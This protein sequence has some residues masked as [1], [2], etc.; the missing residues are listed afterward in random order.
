MWNLNSLGIL[1]L[2]QIFV[3][4]GGSNQKQMLFWCFIALTG[5]VGANISPGRGWGEQGRTCLVT[6]C[7]LLALHSPVTKSLV[8]S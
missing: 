8:L 4:A 7:V 1:P 2:V 6:P 5:R 3:E